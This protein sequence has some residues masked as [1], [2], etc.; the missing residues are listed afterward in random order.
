MATETKP[1][2]V[3]W[4]YDGTLLETEEVWITSE[5]EVM[6]SIG[7]VWTYEQG[8]QMCGASSSIT[9]TT[10][11]DVA[12]EQLGRRPDVHPEVFFEQVYRGVAQHIQ[13]G[14]LP[15]R[16]GALE[17]LEGLNDR[18]VPMAV[19]SASPPDL[20]QAGLRRMPGGLFATAI[21]GPEMPRSK[22]AP[23]GYL[24]AADRLGV[25]PYDCIVIEDSIPGT[26]AGRAA[27]AVVIAVPCMTPLPTA[28]GQVNIDT[29]AG[30]GPDD[31][32]RIWHHVRGSNNG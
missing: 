25:D 4:D 22:P 21:S 9:V 23:D 28:A 8:L 19:V 31:L 24:M 27:G 14:E 6:R 2:A 3:L 17:L 7:V 26:T 13:T 29:L 32:T 11:L 1:T 5:I 12:E 20:L 15:W 18:G 10:M 16:P 30:L